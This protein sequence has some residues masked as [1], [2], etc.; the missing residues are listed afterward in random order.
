[1]IYPNGSNISMSPVIFNSG[2]Y[3]HLDPT[4]SMRSERYN[5]YLGG[6]NEVGGG[7]P[8]GAGMGGN[9]IVPALIPGALSSDL[10]YNVNLEVSGSMKR[11]RLVS[12]STSFNLSASAFLSLI[13]SVS[14]TA[15]IAFDGNGDLSASLGDVLLS[16]TASFSL[17]GSGSMSIK[18]T[19]AG[20]ASF[21]ITGDNVHLT[22]LYAISGTATNY[23]DTS[24]QN[25]AKAVWGADM[26]DN[27]NAGTTGETLYGAGGGSSPTLIAEAVMD[28]FIES[29]INM[30]DAMKIVTAI[31]AGETVIVDTGGGTATVSFKAVGNPGTTRVS[32]SMIDSQ[33]DSLTLNI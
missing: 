25:I 18:A 21:G 24:P 28:E 22:R 11:A 27:R 5:R 1:M 12:G 10:T 16:G 14:G 33:R 2:P 32:A 13:A 29:G 15:P 3:F 30:R 7:L 19:V 31:L 26:N 9:A 20:T 6:F 8:S 23:A 4:L 17:S